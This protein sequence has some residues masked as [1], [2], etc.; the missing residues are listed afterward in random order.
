MKI[1]HMLIAATSGLIAMP[2]LAALPPAY[3]RTAELK[4]ILAHEDLI[5][6]FPQNLP[7]EEVS[8]VGEDHYLVKAGKCALTVRIVGKALPD[9]MVGARQFDVVFDKAECA[10]D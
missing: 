8:Y 1:I 9:G 2:A 7:I 5:A 3:Q 10:E 4:A 6:A